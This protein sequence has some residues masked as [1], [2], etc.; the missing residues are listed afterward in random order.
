MKRH[1]I[2]IVILVSLAAIGI[3]IAIWNTSSVRA[4]VNH[5]LHGFAWSDLPQST[6]ATGVLGAGG[7][8]SFNSLDFDADGINGSDSDC[9]PP[10]CLPVGT[11]VAN[12]GVNVD[13]NGLMSGYAW[14]DVPR[15]FAAG[16]P[17]SIGWI[18][19]N[20]SDLG[21]CPTAPCEAQVITLNG[22]LS[23]WARA[24]AVFLDR[25]G[26]SGSLDPQAGG[27]DGWISLS[28]FHDPVGTPNYG[29]AVG[30]CNWQGW[31]WGGDVLG[32]ISFSN[33]TD[34]SNR[35]YMVS[36]VEVASS[37]GGGCIPVSKLRIALK[38]DPTAIL[39]DPLRLVLRTKPTADLV[40]LYDPDGPG[41]VGETDVTNLAG[42]VPLDSSI[43]DV[44]PAISGRIHAV[45]KGVA[46]IRVEY[47][48]SEMTT[49][50][51]TIDVLPPGKIK[52]YNPGE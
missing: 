48:T 40:A 17:A 26:C 8:I 24:C 38:S 50:S 28:S 42:W 52:E 9:T 29:V 36:G 6:A 19:F 30:T 22:N 51:V 43:V 27:W 47:F 35:P 21:G 34:S 4:G 39:P 11:P 31:A 37:P 18:S 12:Y 33:T 20:S 45:S 15:A 7:W 23:G 14:A 49:V 32:W 44:D 41:G 3:G 1:L 2:F 25:N 10:G 16:V 46:Q 5:N 13:T